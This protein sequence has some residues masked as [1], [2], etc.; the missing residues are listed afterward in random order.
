MSERAEAIAQFFAAMKLGRKYYNTC[1]AKGENPYPLVLNELIDESVSGNT[2]KIGLVD[3]PTDLIVGT[4]TDGRKTAFA[5]NF[6][7]LLDDS[8][9]FGSKWINLCAAHL[10]T[11]GITDPITCLEYL[12]KFYVQ[13]GNKRVSVLKSYNAP[14]IP[15]IVTRI[16][17]P[18]SDDQEVQL[19]YEFID[20]FKVSKTYLVRFSQKGGYAKLQAA[21]GFTPDQVWTEDERRGFSS[22]FRKFSIAFDQLNT[23]KLPITAGD[24]LL[25]YLE[26]HAFQEIKKLTVDELRDSLSS[27]W[28][29]I[30]L[31][32]LGDGTGGKGKEPAFPHPGHAPDARG[33]H[34]R[35][36]PAKERLGR[37]P[38]AGAEVS[39]REDGP[40]RPGFFLYLQ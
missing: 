40:E 31:S 22:D 21:L 9:E 15:G 6:M 34:L 10:S 18:Q 13:E 32:A 1:V 2:V 14:S 26:V 11:T 39:G 29:D 20:F 24:A 28:A 38:L 35:F 12:G 23:E 17:P 37:R 5:G 33:V 27:A 19:Y 4:W 36:R 30:R 25:V 16:L 7:P 3:I 8:T